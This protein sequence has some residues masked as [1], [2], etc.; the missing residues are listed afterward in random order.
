MFQK[1]PCSFSGNAIPEKDIFLTG[2]DPKEAYR[3]AAEYSFLYTGITFIISFFLAGS[4]ASLIPA[5]AEN[6]LLYFLK[7]FLAGSIFFLP[8]AAAA[9]ITRLYGRKRFDNSKN[10]IRNFLPFLPSPVP[11]RKKLF[12][13]FTGT[14][15]CGIFLQIP[16]LLI[17][18][19]QKS[20][21]LKLGIELPPQEKVAMIAKILE[22]G[23]QLHLLLFLIIPPLFF[24]PL[25]E[26]LFFRLILFDKLRIYMKKEYAFPV[27]NILFALLHGNIAAFLPLLLVGCFCQKIYLKTSSLLAAILLHTGFNLST[28]LLLFITHTAK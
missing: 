2:N 21:F 20:I 1:D 7:D 3:K 10:C 8:V 25:A 28:L 22:N 15:F 23:D 16:V 4:I 27:T 24:A 11:Q 18:A 14:F 9:I 6:K 17:S 12:L 13:L 19:V 5:D 26:E